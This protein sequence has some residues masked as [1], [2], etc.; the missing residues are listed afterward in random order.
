ME[1]RKCQHGE[2]YV[3]KRIRLLQ[4]LMKSGFTPENSIPDPD[5]IKYKWWIFINT[6]ELEDCID[7][8]F[9]K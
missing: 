5:N 1:E 2:F 4:Y 8:Y 7:K 3:C 6:P 9:G